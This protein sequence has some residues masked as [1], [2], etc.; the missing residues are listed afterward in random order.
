MEEVPRSKRIIQLHCKSCTTIEYPN[1]LVYT[2]TKYGN[3][4]FVN[5]YEIEMPIISAI[6]LPHNQIFS[7]INGV[8]IPVK[9]SMVPMAVS[10][11]NRSANKAAVSFLMGHLNSLLSI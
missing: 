1:V 10:P 4:R 5:A 8:N 7:L 3:N 9:R 6:G 11:I 2:P